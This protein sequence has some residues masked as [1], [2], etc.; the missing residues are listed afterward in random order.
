MQEQNER[1]EE[2]KVQI[3]KVNEMDVKVSRFD[4][5]STKNNQ[6]RNSNNKFFEELIPNEEPLIQIR[7]FTGAGVTSQ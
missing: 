4:I 2:E 5:L 6:L 1:Q 3:N 7:E